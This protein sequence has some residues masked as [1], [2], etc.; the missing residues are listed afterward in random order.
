MLSHSAN[1]RHEGSRAEENLAVIQ[2]MF[3]ENNRA[4]STLSQL[5]QTP[6]GSSL[7]NPMPLTPAFL[8]LDP[9]WDPL[10]GDRAF[11]KLCEE[12]PH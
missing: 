5:L 2:A 11:Q 4:V 9:F 1:D 6:Y 12:K 7:C 3:G 10:R 8:R